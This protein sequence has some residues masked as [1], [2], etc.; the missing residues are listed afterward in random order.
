MTNLIDG[1][2]RIEIP[3]PFPVGSMNCY[4]I[5]GSPLTLIDTGPKTSE[6]LATIKQSLLNLSYDMSDIEQILITH[7]HL[8]HIGLTAQFVHERKRTHG[9]PTEVWIHFKDANSLTNYEEHAEIYKESFDRL[10]GTS[11]VPK[12][13][14]QKLDPKR[15]IEYYMSLRAPV[16]TARTFKDEAF[17]KTGI[18]EITA[19]WVPGHSS[20]SVCYVCDEQQVIFSGDHILGDISSNPSISFDSPEEIGMVTYLESLNRISSKDGYIAFPGHRKPI[21][22]IKSRIDELHAEYDDKF[23]KARESL[24]SNPKTLYE[25]SRIVYGDYDTN[26]LVLALAESHDL[27]KILEG[28]NQATLITKNGIIHAVSVSN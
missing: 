13:E 5:E 7:G 2:S 4:L 8:D 11:G 6:S 25:L 1:V 12:S 10:I 26:S 22:D 28:R 20:G 15:V 9:N 19:V 23:Q 3:T 16:P 17:F 14:T 27:L 18:G 21:P 24:S